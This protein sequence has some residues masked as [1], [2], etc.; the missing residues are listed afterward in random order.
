MK[1]GA[2]IRSLRGSLISWFIFLGK[3]DELRRRSLPSM[4][5]GRALHS[6]WDLYHSESDDNPAGYG[7]AGASVNF[8]ADQKN[9][10]D[11]S[12]NHPVLGI[13]ANV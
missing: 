6:Y 8:A 9:F 3:I 12:W 5:P 11:F 13:K 4:G 7:F 1:Y 10:Q 2:E